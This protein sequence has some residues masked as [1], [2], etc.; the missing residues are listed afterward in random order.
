M[1]RELLDLRRHFL[2]L[3]ETGD[4]E[5][6]KLLV[7]FG[8]TKPI[9]WDDVLQQRC[10]VV[11]GEAGTGKTTEFCQRSAILRARGVASFFVTI[12]DLASEGLTSSLT[13][14]SE[15][16]LQSWKASNALA[17][18]FLDAVDEARLSGPRFGIFKSALRKLERELGDALRRAHIA[19][20]CRVSDWRAQ[21]DRATVEEI[22]YPEI[23]PGIVR[24]LSGSATS[25]PASEQPNAPGR[26][27]E[28]RL[29]L[30]KPTEAQLK[31]TNVRVYALAPLDDQAVRMLAQS[32]GATE[33]DDFMRAARSAAAHPYLE[34]PRDVEWIVAYWLQHKRLGTLTDLIENDIQE[35]LLER[36][37]DR[38][39][40]QL[41]TPQR[42]KE[43]VKALAGISLL[44]RRLTFRLPD[45]E[46]DAERAASSV[47]PAAVL[48]DLQPT[49]LHELLT[50]PIFDEAT[51]GR[52]RIHHRSVTE[53]LAAE[54]LQS[55][56]DNGFSTADMGELLFHQ[57]GGVRVVPDEL[58]PVAVWLAASNEAVRER[59]LDI[60]P[61]SF[62]QMGDPSRFSIEFRHRLLA[63]VASLYKDRS[64]L[65]RST[66]R[67][68]LRRLGASDM[69]S[70]LNALL[71]V[72]TEDE[73]LETLIAIVAEG[74]L[75]E[76]AEEVLRIA[77][78]PECPLR[79]RAEAIRTIAKI[80]TSAQC[81]TV[82]RQMNEQASTISHDLGGVLL[83]F[84]PKNM[85]VGQ[86]AEFLSRVEPPPAHTVTLLLHLLGS[87]IYHDTAE[88]QRAHLLEALTAL[89]A[90][91]KIHGQ[92]RW[93][94]KPL[95]QLTSKLAADCPDQ[96]EPTLVP[97]VRALLN[98][99]QRDS[100]DPTYAETELRRFLSQ[101]AI[102]RIVFWEQ[103]S[104]ARASN[105]T[106]SSCYDVMAG[107]GAWNPRHEDAA[108]LAAA[109]Q[110][111]GRAD[112]RLV[113][114]DCL[115]HLPVVDGKA[116]EREALV[117]TIGASDPV[118]NQR[119]EQYLSTNRLIGDQGASRRAA[120]S[121][122]EDALQEQENLEWLH[123][124]IADLR[125]AKNLGALDYL[126]Q[127]AGIDP[128]RPAE[129]IERI[130][131][132]YDGEIATAVRQGLR[133]A[134]RRI[135]CPL[136]HEEKERNS[137]SSWMLMGLAGL[138]LDVEDG[139]DFTF[140]EPEEARH[141]A[142]Y[143]TRALNTYPQWL[144]ALVA[145][146]R[147]TVFGVF[148]ECLRVDF[149]HPNG[150]P[151]IHATLHMLPH[152]S[153]AVREL[154]T[155]VVLELLREGDPPRA[156]TLESCL[157]S[158][159][160]TSTSTTRD[161]LA[162]FAPS[163]CDL[164][165]AD[166]DRSSLWWCSWLAVDPT[167]A[168]LVLE[169][170]IAQVGPDADDLVLRLADRIWRFSEDAQLGFTFP[171]DPKARGKLTQLIIA[172][173]R[174]G[175]DVRH[176]GAHAYGARDHAESLRRHLL[177]M[178]VD[179]PG[180]EAYEA[181]THI[182]DLP[183]M[184]GW[185]DYIL[186][187]AEKQLS[188]DARAHPSAVSE[189]LIALY[190][191]HGLSAISHLKQA[192][193]TDFVIVTALPVE[194]EA[195]CAALG[196]GDERRIKVGARVVWRGQMPLPKG[197]AYNIVVAQ[198]PDAAN[199]DSALLT[200]DLL[201]DWNP[202]A[203]LMVGIAATTDTKEAALGDVVAGRDVYYYE[204]GKVTPGGT[205]PEPRTM[206]PD[207]TLW[208]NVESLPNWIPS[209]P[210]LR[211]DGASTLPKLRLGVIASGEKVLADVAARDHIVAG[212]RKVIAV[213]MEGYGFS[214]AVWA[215]FGQV[216][217]LVIRGI[218]DDGTIGKNDEWHQYA[219]ASV[220]DLVKQF[221]LD[222]PLTP[223]SL[224]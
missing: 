137:F 221:L 153:S 129:T 33:P 64:R 121:E 161:A 96:C 15:Q 211:P 1:R 119:L 188:Q 24:Q 179:T 176:H 30:A 60:A 106:A 74:G 196:F 209:L 155:P 7:D 159:L 117:A 57:H 46:L 157:K 216:R 39:K 80:G 186:S 17:Y 133:Q 8:V 192:T 50:R 180:S 183:R 123:K 212:H 12:D 71:R 168:L 146:Q 193:L 132:K 201:R 63:A 197:G 199:V 190:K 88:D 213:E 177:D 5:A 6:D 195:M 43:A 144:D 108:W 34:R 172:H 171:R 97:L 98:A 208:N 124:H 158:L 68:T 32:L 10:V 79:A 36:N 54:W 62:L 13:T 127:A 203:A 150:A 53:F 51:Y 83:D 41:M 85:N 29:S 2:E 136:P 112:D 218:C 107:V 69:V 100:V 47:D 82:L 139:L 200:A 162:G 122:R 87:R 174:P 40:R 140:L 102:R 109:A 154:C 103:V 42:A 210:I 130:G 26:R 185:R 49:E 152:A 206:Q 91:G 9:A 67:A 75:K 65:F 58:L 126:T 16:Q 101:S 164:R 131:T 81:E 93:M 48:S 187:L 181:L 114:F 27:V 44:E 170:A 115:I 59:L 184:A 128:E 207:S 142:C 25:S 45:G 73:L 143:A 178:L 35:K 189:Y 141:A 204:R 222:R 55:L 160:A 147:T 156:D 56:A 89:L 125:D 52:V 14:T 167:P 61:L 145:A 191:E 105:P 28:E 76:C 215:N 202:Q 78:S 173:V 84:Y 165:N 72:S 220:A 70:S 217:H 175:D 37:S 92:R 90:D 163:R 169:E 18:F 198:A 194:R 38:A 20:S 66:D 99:S 104:N 110:T 22:L 120:S 219:A 4:E 23:L 31:T 111:C 148:R 134:W 135:Q 95:A 205:K 214:R 3:K 21:S 94:L 149:V 166:H 182:A 86:L 113:A 77:T 223:R 138:A 11:L 151:S 118:L 116:S 224:G 19:I